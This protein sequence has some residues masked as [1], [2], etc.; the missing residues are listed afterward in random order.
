MHAIKQVA[1]HQT[2]TPPAKY[3]EPRASGHDQAD[4]VSVGIE[5]S[6]Q[7]SFPLAVFVQFIQHRHRRLLPEAIQLQSLSQRGRTTQNAPPV[8]AVVP[9]EIVIAKQS[10]N[11]SL[12]DLPG[13]GN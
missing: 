2:V 8:I 10:T 3:V 7:E 1:A 13:S 12:S 11:R 9:V 4:L 6:F 5:E